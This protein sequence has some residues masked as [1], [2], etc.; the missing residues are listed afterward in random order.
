MKWKTL[1]HHG[2]L[3]PEPYVV[4]NVPIIYDSKVT[5][6][7][8]EAEEFISYY[9]DPRYDKYKDS[10]F[11]NNFFKDWKKLLNPELAKVITN[12]KLVDTSIMREFVIERKKIKKIKPDVEKYKFVEVDGR[13]EEIENFAIE[14]PALYLGKESHPKRGSIKKRIMPRDVTINISKEYIDVLPKLDWGEI[15]ENRDVEWIS[16]FRHPVTGKIIY[17]KFGRKSSIKK[18]NNMQKFELA[19]KLKKN[20]KHIRDENYE[21]LGS[22]DEKIQQMAVATYLIDKLGIRVGNE[23]D[24]DVE[25][26]TIGTTTL[27]VRN[28]ELGN[29]FNLTLDFIGK[30]SVRYV[31]TVD[32]DEKV[33]NLLKKFIEGKEKNEQVFDKISSND[34]NKY[35]NHFMKKLT[36]KVFRT[37]NA[38]TLFQNEL[39]NVSLKYKNLVVNES[40]EVEV[41]EE[42]VDD[43]HVNK[44][45]PFVEKSSVNDDILKENSVVKEPDLDQ[46]D[47]I[48]VEEKGVGKE[49]FEKI[50][51]DYI[52]ANVKVAKFC[53]HQKACGKNFLEKVRR[54]QDKVKELQSRRRKLSG[55]KNIKK[56]KASLKKKID[57]LRR[58]IVVLQQSKSLATSTSK[59]NYIDPRITFAFIKKNHL[60]NYIGRFFNKKQLEQ[61]SWAADVESNFNF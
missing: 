9:A 24:T 50:Y 21:N 12:F 38:S 18:S 6:L 4:S 44:M 41:G 25:A 29:D 61:F 11:N 34:L 45:D 43:R 3:F 33:Y 53:N 22:G 49:L 23:K 39:K 32:V 31:N 58:K 27:E 1:K 2:V 28:V 54:M 36:A 40:T 52:L 55:G 59:D 20:I 56:R 10:V 13:I 46:V 26:G 16:A 35:L 19:R 30:D 57:V 60:E 37:Y 7:N 5:S 8:P 17:C 14:P 48:K 51:H 15:I 42:I 47:I